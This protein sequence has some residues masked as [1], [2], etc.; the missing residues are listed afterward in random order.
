MRASSGDAR[1][2]PWTTA[3]GEP[4]YLI[5]D[6]TGRVSRMADRIEREQLSMADELLGHAADMLADRRSTGDQV[7]YLACRLAESLR[8]VRRVAESRRTATAQFPHE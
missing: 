2:L 6:G 5:G 7:H 4:C 1:L 3:S 8:E